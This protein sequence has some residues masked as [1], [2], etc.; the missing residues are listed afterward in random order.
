MP[1]C[2][3]DEAL[4]YELISVPDRYL[5]RYGTVLYKPKIFFCFL[6]ISRVGYRGID[7]ASVYDNEKEV[8]LAIEDSGIPRDQIFVQ[9]KLWR[10]FV[11]EFPPVLWIRDPVPF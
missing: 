2:L 4:N 6:L 5:P 7:T 11:G 3:R 8:G 9:T 1:A 10:S